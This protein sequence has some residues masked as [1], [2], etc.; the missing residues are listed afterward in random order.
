MYVFVWEAKIKKET[1]NLRFT[2]G[3]LIFHSRMNNVTVSTW[4]VSE[5]FGRS[6]HH[7]GRTLSVDRPLHGDKL[8][9]LDRC[10]IWENFCGIHL[11]NLLALCYSIYRDGRKVWF[12]V[13]RND[14]GK[15][16]EVQ[17]QTLQEISNQKNDFGWN[18]KVRARKCCPQLRPR[19][20][21]LRPRS[22]FFTI[23]PS[24]PTNTI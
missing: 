11:T 14:W 7:S 16:F 23:R 8:Y 15:C 22:Q 4:L 19:A 2:V 6:S 12:R 18:F 20:A 10:C 24:Q 5:V 3:D 13:I 1:N 17:F 9:F 21:F